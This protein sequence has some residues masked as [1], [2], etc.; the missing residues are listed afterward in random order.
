M[1]LFG[2]VLIVRIACVVHVVRSGR[3]QIWIYVIIFPPAAGCLVHLVA[4]ILPELFRSRAALP[5]QEPA[6]LGDDRPRPPEGRRDRTSL[7]RHD[8]PL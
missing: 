3:N 6:R 7:K 8:P 2:L 5:S 4:E 1:P